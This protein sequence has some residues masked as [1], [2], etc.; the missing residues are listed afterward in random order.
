MALGTLLR[1]DNI[2]KTRRYKLFNIL[3]SVGGIAYHSFVGEGNDDML[4]TFVQNIY[5]LDKSTENHEMRIANLFLFGKT[6]PDNPI[7]I[8]QL[9]NAFK[10]KMSEY[11]FD[12]GIY[13]MLMQE[14]LRATL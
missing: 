13:R 7:D 4:S 3:K 6:R 11:L 8:G 12:F 9:R 10:D 14:N 5:G 2:S 1:N